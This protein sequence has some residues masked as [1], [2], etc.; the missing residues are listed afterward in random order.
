MNLPT[1][2]SLTRLIAGP[3]IAALIVWA[4]QSLFSGGPIM[5]ARLYGVSAVLFI[6]AAATDA[7]DGMLA[8][9][10]NAV[11]P[12]GAALDHVADK[13][14]IASVL[15]ALA[16]AALPL[17]LIAVA[18]VLIG[19]DLAIAGLRESMGARM[20]V[21]GLGKLKALTAMSGVAAFLAFQTWG[22]IAGGGVVASGLLWL[23]RTLLWMAALLSLWS[24]A[25]YVRAAFAPPAA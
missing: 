12:L 18:I 1:A 21:D 3:L 10:T 11:T 2:L 24:G 25:R 13:V 16:Y 8:R 23:A 5:A 14:L 7:L 17:D 22:I 6:A 15:I 9:R 4:H 20:P 19:R